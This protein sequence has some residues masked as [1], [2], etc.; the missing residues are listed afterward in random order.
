MK[1]AYPLKSDVRR[2]PLQDGGTALGRTTFIHIPASLRHQTGGIGYRQLD[3][4]AAEMFGLVERLVGGGDKVAVFLPDGGHQTRDADAQQ[5]LT[6][7]EIVRAAAGQQARANP[8]CEISRILKRRVRQQHGEF[9]AAITRA[10]IRRALHIRGDR[11]GNGL[12]QLV[13][14]LMLDW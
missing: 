2:R 3:P 12:Q 4:V 13:A 9:I 5:Y 14:R 8:L 11:C 7:L 10:E 1:A 6:G